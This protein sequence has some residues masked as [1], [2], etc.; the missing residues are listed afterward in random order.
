MAVSASYAAVD[1]GAESG[2]VMLGLFDGARLT[3]E[4]AHRFPNNPVRA[5]DT[6][7]WDVLRLWAD[8][9]QGLAA[10]ARLT[11]GALLSVGVD[12]WGVDFGLLGRD[13]RLL[14]NPVH[15]R[16]GRTQGMI[17]LACR[18]VGRETLFE[19]TGI[20]FMPFNTLYQLLAMR[21]HDSP[22]LDA[23]ERLLNMPDLLHFWLSGVKANEFT[24]A[25]TTQCYDPRAGA[26]AWEVLEKLDLPTRLFGPV[27]PPG[28]LLGP[29]QAALAAELGLRNV[30]VITPAS[31]DTGSAVAAVPLEGEDAVYLS[32][33]TWSLMGVERPQPLI[34]ARSLADNFTNEGGVDGSFRLLKNIMGLWLVQECR[35]A[36]TSQGEAY[37]YADLIRLAE[38]APAFVA[39]IDASDTRWLAPGGMPAR[40][41]AYC[42]ATG[43][44]GPESVG[45]IVRAILE[46]LALEYAWVAERLE[47]LNGR[48]LG[49]IHVIGGGARNGLLNQLTADA[50]GRRVVAGP[51]EATALGNVLV[52]AM[53]AGHVP[54]VAE[55]RALVRQSFPVET[56][57]PRPSE[58]WQAAYQ[59]YLGLKA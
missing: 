33:G 17:D 9:Q 34:D 52:Q 50:T 59:L 23:A 2:R 45:A 53:A 58:A 28:T 57:E 4:E 44:R 16:D 49:T 12:T 7:Y 39:L 46:S 30:Q 36:W 21:A 27:V 41:R 6:L 43:Q 5:G 19:R 11:D 35:R 25:T 29:L 26:W 20:Q 3:L 22:Q 37:T 10:C 8:I 47:K 31:H 51:I 32:S 14:A 54:S 40:I 15:Y 38:R 24:I 56:Y 1:L 55:G 13:D 18:R 42:H 48:P